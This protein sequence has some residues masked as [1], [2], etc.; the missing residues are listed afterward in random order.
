MFDDRGSIF[1]LD[2]SFN[3]NNIN[4]IFDSEFPDDNESEGEDS[5]Q[6][7]N[8]AI[9]NI[10]E[11]RPF[12]DHDYFCRQSTCTRMPTTLEAPPIITASPDQFVIWNRW[13]GNGLVAVTD[14]ALFT[15]KVESDEEK[16]KQFWYRR[17]NYLVAYN[18]KVLQGGEFEQPATLATIDESNP[19]QK[20][21]LQSVNENDDF[22][23]LVSFHNGLV[24]HYLQN[25]TE[26]D[27][28]RVG[29]QHP[30]RDSSHYSSMWK[31]IQREEWEQ[32]D[33]K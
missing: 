28:V 32:S 18:G 1:G 31:L 30:N 17:D 6:N 21:I 5:N 9:M 23:Y 7:E 19:K 3:L 16:A 10:D 25:P 26:T 33:N 15:K 8:L 27:V 24:L 14:D 20:W 13:E 11:N 2:D 12:G 4:N 29:M 22:Y